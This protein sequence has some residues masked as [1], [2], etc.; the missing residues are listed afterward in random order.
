MDKNE[1][2]IAIYKALGFVFGVALGYNSDQAMMW[3]KLDV[4][5]PHRQVVTMVDDGKRYS[6]VTSDPLTDLNA[7]HEAQSI[8]R[9]C[10][11]WKKFC[12]I[13][14]NICNPKGLKYKPEIEA[15]AAQRAEAFLKTLNL[16]TG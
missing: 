4:N 12:K 3:Y 1:Q 10:V 2:R 8:E 15:T 11:D 16:W 7:M 9:I 5:G 6:H 14:E 13:L